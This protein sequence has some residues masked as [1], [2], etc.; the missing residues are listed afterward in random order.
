MRPARRTATKS[1][2]GPGCALQRP[3]RSPARVGGRRP[4]DESRGINHLKGEA[5]GKSKRSSRCSCTADH[6]SLYLHTHVCYTTSSALTDMLAKIERRCSSPFWSERSRAPGQAHRHK[7][8][9]GAGV[10]TPA[11]V[12]R[13]HTPHGVGTYHTAK[14]KRRS[15]ATW[16]AKSMSLAGWARTSMMSSTGVATLVHPSALARQSSPLETLDSEG[17]R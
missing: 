8:G 5:G 2:S 13:T 1:V 6:Q 11:P 15:G 16:Q 14:S 7:I 3:S 4:V 10:R 9:V 17:T 12:R